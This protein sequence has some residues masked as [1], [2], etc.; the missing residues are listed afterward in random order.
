MSKPAV[1][2][3]FVLI[4][5]AVLFFA[6]TKAPPDVK[7]NPAGPSV[8]AGEVGQ[9]TVAPTS[10]P[11]TITKLVI[12]DT[13][14]GTGSAVKV[15]DTVTINYEGKLE[16]GQVFDSSYTRGQPFVTQIG[17]GRVI[18]GWDQ[19]IIGL[20]VGGKRHL[21]IPSNLAYGKNGVPGAIPPDSTLIFDVELVAVS[22]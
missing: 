11:S 17:V 19:G 1:I 10:M 14:V 2:T 4:V 9:P 8:T 7:I 22:Q 12:T 18:P 21:V 16:N 6:L 5:A 3:L 20:K 15:G 13:K